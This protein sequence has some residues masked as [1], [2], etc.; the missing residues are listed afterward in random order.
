MAAGAINAL[1]GG[2][3]LVSF[4][5]LVGL[6]VPAVNANV[7]NTV[8]LVPG[9]LGGSWAQRDDLV[10]QLDHARSLAA[11]SAAGGLAG[12]VL[13]V[14]IPG[15]VFRSAVPYLILLS[16]VLL[17]AQ[18]QVRGWISRDRDRDPSGIDAAAVPDHDP[19]GVDAGA[20]AGA[21]APEVPTSTRFKS[22]GGMRAA[23][24]ISVFLAAVYGGFFGAG[25]GIMLLAVLALFTPGRL[26]ATNA[27]KQA[28]SFVINLVAAV[29]FAF[30]GHVVWELVPIMAA[31]SVTGGLIGGRFVTAVSEV[32]LRRVVV[33]T[34]V[35]VALLFWV[36]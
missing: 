27:L 3:T 15:H 7:T 16:C 28:L 6:G 19:P 24:M 11:V 18:D 8:A 13:L 5:T 14:V 32:W 35:A 29:L 30:S 31:A 26:T 23:L 22:S 12:S 25:L 10:P 4:P 34:G 33:S 21:I 1:A 20:D 17:L 9:Y 36:S 2:G